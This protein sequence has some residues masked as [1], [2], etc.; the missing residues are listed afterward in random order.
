MW[1]FFSLNKKK[2][3]SLFF[4]G[5]SLF[6]LDFGDSDLSSVQV[7]SVSSKG[8]LNNVL[9]FEFDIA[10]SS[11]SFLFVFNNS[12]FL[13]VSVLLKVTAEFN[14]SSSETQVSDI[15]GVIVIV[16]G[17]IHSLLGLTAVLAVTTA[18]SSSGS[19]GATGLSGR[20]FF[21]IGALKIALFLLLSQGLST[22]N[23]H[24]SFHVSTFNFLQGFF[25]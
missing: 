4:S 17:T 13:D 15:N 9:V 5:L 3:F 1:I 8:L 22:D 19:S 14:L 12:H 11:G 20:S 18:S 7:G 24:D 2:S 25:E 6:L 21:G 16:A 23:F 10:E